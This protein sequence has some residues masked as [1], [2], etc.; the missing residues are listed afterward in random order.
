MRFLSVSMLSLCL[1]G[2]ANHMHPLQQEFTK[3][4]LDAGHIDQSP[5]FTSCMDAHWSER[6]KQ[7]SEAYRQVEV[8]KEKAE[9]EAAE[10]QLKD[11]K[12]QCKDYGLKAGTKNFASCLIQLSADR[13]AL[14]QRQAQQEMIREQI[15]QQARNRQTQS[16]QT[17]GALDVLS[18][19]A[20]EQQ[21]INAANMPRPPRTINCSDDKLGGQ[22]FTCME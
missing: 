20:R 2:C 17:S 6:Q 21:R 3:A 19:W 10:R 15:Q 7:I 1:L 9:K 13:K 18:N 11:D 4:C 5:E 22:S 12:A 14:T 16:Q 8:R